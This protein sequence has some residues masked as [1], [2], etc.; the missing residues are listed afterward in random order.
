MYLPYLEW[1]SE[2]LF[3]FHLQHKHSGAFANRK[4]EELSYP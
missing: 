3:T 4:F 1:V 2:E